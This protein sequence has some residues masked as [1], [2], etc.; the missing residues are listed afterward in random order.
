MKESTVAFRET[1]AGRIR[2]PLARKKGVEGKKMFGGIRFL[3]NGDLLDGVWKDSPI[4]RLGPEDGDEGRLE[5]HIRE[6]DLTGKPMK[7]WVVVGPEGVEEDGQLKEWIV[8]ATKFVRP[9]PGRWTEPEPHPL[10]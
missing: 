1:L 2:D 7:G 4:V 6:F 3:L 9:L 8:R 10:R 5:P